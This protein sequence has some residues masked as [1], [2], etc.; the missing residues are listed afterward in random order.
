M[1]RVL[2]PVVAVAVE[3]RLQNTSIGKT[4]L[5]A[6]VE[7]LPEMRSN[8]RLMDTR[9]EGCRTLHRYDGANQERRVRPGFDRFVFGAAAAAVTAGSVA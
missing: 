3:G 5:T 8:I 9:T 1:F 2:N 6:S 4:T 7:V